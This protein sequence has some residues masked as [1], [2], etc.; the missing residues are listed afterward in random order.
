MA[1]GLKLRADRLDAFLAAFV[2]YTNERLAPADLVATTLIDTSTTAA[3]LS[4]DTVARMAQ[5]APFGRENPEPRLLLENAVIHGT[6]R[7]FG[8][9]GNHVMLDIT[10]ESRPLKVKFWNGAPILAKH[11]VRLAHNSHLNLVGTPK[12]DTW[13]GNRRVELTLHDLALANA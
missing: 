9:A 12:L 10:H 11:A 5:L 2:S 13:N 6:P 8:S 4:F 7:T 1:A 3:E